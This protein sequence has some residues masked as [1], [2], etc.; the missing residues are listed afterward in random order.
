MRRRC[1]YRGRPDLPHDACPEIGDDLRCNPRGA[2]IRIATTIRKRAPAIPAEMNSKETEV[3]SA[4]GRGILVTNVTP[5]LRTSDLHDI[6]T[7]TSGGTWRRRMLAGTVALS[8]VGGL[9]AGSPAIIAAQDG[10]GASTPVPPVTCVI[11]VATW[12]GTSA[13]SAKATATTTTTASTPIPASTPGSTPMA[14]ASPASSAAATPPLLASPVSPTTTALENDL[15]ASATAVLKCLS[16]GNVDQLITFTSDTFRGQL[17]GSDQPINATDYAVLAPTLPV[18][19]Y[20]LISVTDV[21]SSGKDAA[22]AAVTYSVGKQIRT[23]TWDFTLGKV[24]GKQTWTLQSETPTA[25]TTPATAAKVD[26]AIKGNA[27]TLSPAKINSKDV[28]FTIKNG[29]AEDH[30]MLVVQLASGTKSDALLTNTGAGLPKGVTFVGQVTVPASGEGQLLLS[31]LAKGT[32]TVVD[33][34]PGKDGLPHLSGG[35][36][37]TFTVE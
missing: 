18:L 37:A 15:T 10:T 9:L 14:G 22:S 17:I 4:T 11:P 2:R 29:D 25:V 19:P 8:L 27:F 7:P 35:M 30:E 20:S 13:S 34:F 3:A 28:L 31:E 26:V 6:A 33:L 16:G 12:N 1:M 24:N 21:T 23:A 36:E 32:Y 5:I